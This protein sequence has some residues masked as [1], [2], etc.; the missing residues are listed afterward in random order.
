MLIR[1]LGSVH[2]LRFT[3]AGFAIRLQQSRKIPSSY[4]LGREGSERGG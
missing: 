4:S 2:A 1:T 3:P